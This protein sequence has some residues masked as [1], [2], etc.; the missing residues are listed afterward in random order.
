[1]YL[2]II[3]SSYSQKICE[4]FGLKDHFRQSL[5]IILQL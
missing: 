5:S 2:H 4:A 3:I 1:M